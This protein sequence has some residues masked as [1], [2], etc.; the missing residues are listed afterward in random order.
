M[1]LREIAVSESFLGVFLQ[2]AGV[3][4]SIERK[5]TVRWAAV[6]PRQC[7]Y[8]F[9][10]F[11]QKPNEGICSEY[12]TP[13]KTFLMAKWRV[14]KRIGRRAAAAS[15]ISRDLIALVGAAPQVRS[16]LPLGAIRKRT[17]AIFPGTAMNTKF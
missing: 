5:A 10:S 15:S 2:S 16:S 17:Q 1:S 11:C 4:A 7:S 12:I 3:Y 6:G 9:W 14:S 13:N 8:T